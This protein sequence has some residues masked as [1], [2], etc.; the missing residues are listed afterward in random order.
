MTT[1]TKDVIGQINDQTGTAWKALGPMSGGLQSGATR[2]IAADG[3]L[4]VVKWSPRPEWARRVVSAAPVVRYAR[5]RGY[6]TPAWLAVG[7]TTE[8]CPWL[9]YEYLD[10]S[11]A[12]RLGM[13]E[14]EF[15]IS[16]VSRAV[17]M[18]PPT[19]VDWSAY[20]VPYVFEDLRGHQAQLRALGGAVTQAVDAV[21]GVAQAFQDVS[22][23]HG[24]LV[25]GDLS[26]GNLICRDGEPL[27]V[28]D[29]E[30]VGRGTAIYDLM[31]VLRTAYMD[32]AADGVVPMLESAA[33]ELAEPEVIALCLAT[34]VIEILQ[35]GTTHFPGSLQTCASRLMNW[36]A[37]CRRL[38]GLAA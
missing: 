5:D 16:L 15:L 9:V 17:G 25:H 11:P 1:T 27:G 6:P 36:V 20:I 4:A 31:C 38:I 37:D 12:A 8:G 22:L 7:T 10:G 26:L 32:G 35:F 18:E 19:E 33:T 24:D 2:I 34:Q 30:A 21:V 28:V 14:A 13:A 23:P 3:L 29:I